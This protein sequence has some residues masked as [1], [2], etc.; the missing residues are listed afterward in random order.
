MVTT[1][2]ENFH[3]YTILDYPVSRVETIGDD[4]AAR[5]FYLK[6]YER[7]RGEPVWEGLIRKKIKG[8]QK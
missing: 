8:P 4:A 2:T 7:L 1:E 6:T 5:E 3:L